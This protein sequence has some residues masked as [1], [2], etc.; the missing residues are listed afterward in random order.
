MSRNGYNCRHPAEL[1]LLKTN[2]RK[3]LDKRLK[4]IVN[5]PSYRLAYLDFDYLQREDLRPLRLQLELLKPEMILEEAG[6]KSTVVV[7]GGTQVVPLDEAQQQMADARFA[8][9]GM[10]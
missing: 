6:I 2:K 10:S 5:H 8:G 9:G 4:E 7:F 1:Q 3:M